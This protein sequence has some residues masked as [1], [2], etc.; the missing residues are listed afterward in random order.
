MSNEQVDNLIEE[1]LE[2]EEKTTAFSQDFDELW[3]EVK[4]FL[5]LQ[6]TDEALKALTFWALFLWTSDIH[7]DNTEEEIVVRFRIDG[8]LTD[9]FHLTKQEYKILIER[10][11][12]SSNL[13]LNITN[14]PQDWKYWVEKEWK[15]LDIRVSTL[16]IKYWENVVARILDS[17]KAILTFKDLWF[18][19]TA[20]RLMK[21]ALEKKN[22][23]ILVTWPTGSWKTTSLYTMLSMLN[24]RDKKVI[25]LEDPTEYEL[26]G[27]IQAEVNPKDGFDYTNGIKALLRQDPDIIMIWEI[28]DFETLNTSASASLTWHL[29]LSTLHTKSATETL[30]RIIN[31][32][33]KP[34]IMASAL[35]TIVAQRLVRKICPHCKKEKEKTKNEEALI[36][37][38][39]KDT[40]MSTLKAENTKLYHWEWCEKCN[41]TWYKWRVWVY[42]ILSLNETIRDM[43]REWATTTEII[44]ASRKYDFISM[45]EDWILKALKW[46]TTIEEIIRVI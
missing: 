37:K 14:I 11:K 39:L 9:I 20:E 40:W 6:Q 24:T 42:E 12:F 44:E 29:V 34:Y 32:W 1:I 3:E 31:M 10:I 23:L 33:L 7:L 18:F 27:I 41:H 26:P 43:I 22:W 35:D 30:N 19:W 2:N 5:K 28:R 17:E 21:K 15:K 38:M 36:K 8:I 16:P 13:K 25:T 46:H 45:K 4:Q